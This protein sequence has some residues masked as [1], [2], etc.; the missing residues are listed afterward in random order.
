VCCVWSGDADCGDGAITGSEECDI[1]LDRLSQTADD[2]L[3]GRDCVFL[4]YSSGTLE[5]RD[6]CTFDESGCEGCGMVCG[7]R[8]GETCSMGI[9]GVCCDGVQYWTGECCSPA[10]CDSGEI[11]NADHRCTLCGNGVLDG[12]ED[13]ELPGDD[14][15]GP[16]RDCPPTCE[17]PADPDEPCESLEGGYC[18]DGSS[19]PVGSRYTDGECVGSICCVVDFSRIGDCEE[20]SGV[21]RGFMCEGEPEISAQRES[22]AAEAMQAGGS[23]LGHLCCATDWCD[24]PSD[25]PDNICRTPTCVDNTCG[26]EIIINDFDPLECD[27]TAANGDCSMPPCWCGYAGNCIELTCANLGGVCQYNDCAGFGEVTAG[28]PQCQES[29]GSNALCC[30]ETVSGSCVMDGNICTDECSS[31]FSTEIYG[32]CEPNRCCV[33]KPGTSCKDNTGGLAAYCAQRASS[34]ECQGSAYC[35]WVSDSCTNLQACSSLLLT[36]CLQTRPYCDWS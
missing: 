27:S 10:D 21:C 25:C 34:P 8:P 3:D 14:A 26:E 29:Y 13:C 24:N 16:G 9:N 4:G 22:C 2:D 1:G 28:I 18:Y 5:C 35:E 20:A 12:G 33:P 23:P 30:E 36:E 17:C 6:D 15:C 32:D 19:C 7:D 31:A 11:C